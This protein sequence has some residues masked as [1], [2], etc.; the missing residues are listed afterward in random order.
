MQDSINEH[1]AGGMEFALWLSKL[2]LSRPTGYRYRRDGKVKTHNVEGREFILT[3][4]II[5][6]WVRVKAGEF[7]KAPRGAS[8]K[9]HRAASKVRAG[10]QAEHPPALPKSAAAD[11]VV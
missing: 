6:F 10:G 1:D 3:E 7:A 9:R 11:P 8:A 4:E 5:R 2:G